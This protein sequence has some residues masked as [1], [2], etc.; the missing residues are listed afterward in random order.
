[1][2]EPN[3]II[4][5]ILVENGGTN[6]D[7]V[8]V[9]VVGDSSAFPTPFHSCFPQEAGFALTFWGDPLV[10]KPSFSERQPTVVIVDESFFGGLAPWTF[11]WIVGRSRKVLVTVQH[12]TVDTQEEFILARCEGVLARK[13]PP[14][15]F[16]R[17]VRCLAAGQLWMSRALVA[18]TLQEVLWKRVGPGLSRREEEIANLVKCR[19]SNREIAAR[20]RISDETVRWHLRRVYSKLGIHD[21]SLILQFE[22]NGETRHSQA[23]PG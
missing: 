7:R 2:I 9:V 18:H 12:E 16:R 1:M 20:L 19:F 4:G 17:A 11:R 6:R 10:E 3:S 14:S 21:R 13:A 5:E 15:S 23:I 8:N 22:Q